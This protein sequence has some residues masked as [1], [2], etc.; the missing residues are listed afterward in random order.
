MTWFL[1]LGGI[2]LAVP[3]ALC[4]T[5]LVEVFRQLAEIRRSL[6]LEDLPTPLALRN[7]GL[8]VK[9]IG[10]PAQLT[11][12]PAAI[13]IVLSARCTT[14]LA[15]AEA[16][17]VGTPTSVWFVLPT[18]PHPDHLLRTLSQSADR[19]ILDENE[20]IVDAIDLR[21][22]PAVLTLSF[23]EI[24][25]AH[26]VSSPRQLMSLVP[27]VLPANGGTIST[28]PRVSAVAQPQALKGGGVT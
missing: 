2:A 16:L 15:I 8:D 18:P 22:T 25:R 17:R 20:V 4:C 12:A 7:R 26:A 14:C 6:N 23:G 11:E 27:T 5:A 19:I 28:S 13:V 10:L 1:L 21:V 24:T 3:V 9:D